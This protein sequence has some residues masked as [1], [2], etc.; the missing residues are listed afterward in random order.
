MSIWFLRNCAYFNVWSALFSSFISV[1]I[2]CTQPQTSFTTFHCTHKK[3]L[4]TAKIKTRRDLHKISCSGLN[5]NEVLPATD[6]SQGKTIPWHC[7]LKIDLLYHL[8]R[9]STDKWLNNDWHCKT[10]VFWA[11]Y[12]N[13]IP[14]SLCWSQIPQ[15]ALPLNIS[16]CSEN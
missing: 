1:L 7:R 14:L 4:N 10:E 2:M 6:K 16:F 9:R 15:T 13:S 11:F 5:S 3:C 12:T 8:L